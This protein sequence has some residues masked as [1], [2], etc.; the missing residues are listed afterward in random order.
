[1]SDLVNED[2][3][4]RARRDPEFRQ[5]L[6][7]DNLERLLQALND[8]RKVPDNKSRDAARQIRE[9]V[10]LAVKLAERLQRDNQGGPRAA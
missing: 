6:L 8:M 9:G 2:D 7:A 4:E 3:L 10:D 5:Q 1:M